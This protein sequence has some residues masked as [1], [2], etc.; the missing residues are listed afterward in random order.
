MGTIWDK[1]W[2]L[3]N[4]LEDLCKTLDIPCPA[5]ERTTKK[6]FWD[7]FLA[8]KV[9]TLPVSVAKEY[10]FF[11][12]MKTSEFDEIYHELYNPWRTNQWG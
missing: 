6:L 3:A 2:P 1:Q 7:A 5:Y 4:R 9:D 12:G 11:M 10:W 8:V